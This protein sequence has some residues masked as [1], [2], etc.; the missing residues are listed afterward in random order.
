MLSLG[1]VN[2]LT[3]GGRAA[4]LATMRALVGLCAGEPIEVNVDGG[5]ELVLQAG[6]PPVI[7]GQVDE[8]MRVGCGSAAIGLS[9]SQGAPH[10]AEVVVDDDHI[11]GVLTE[12]QAGVVL[13][14]A[15]SGIRLRGRKSTPGRYFEVAEPGSGWGGT[16]LEDP[17]EIV[18]G[19]KPSVAR[20][21]QTLL[22]IS[23]T[24]NDHAFYV[25]DDDLRL[26]PASLPPELAASV[27]R[28]RENCEPTTTSVLFMAGAGGSLRAGVTDDPVQLTRSVS[29]DAATLTCGGAPTFVWPGGG[30]TFMVDVT[31]T[32][33]GSF[34]YVP[35][36]ALV[37]PLEF[38][39][40]LDTYI[41]L[42]GHAGSIVPVESAL[43]GTPTRLVT[44]HHGNPWPTDPDPR[45]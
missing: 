28:V 34:G 10:V 38:T 11:T 36:P 32:P 24:G 17:L 12:H 5:S 33:P 43:T 21:G 41:R 35:T 44:A 37:A 14:I 27:E 4:G 30:I 42:G 45:W 7:D 15:P 19:F 3:G 1:G 22:M 20:P 25:L 16:D 8:R 13:G 18:A 2:H 26:R 6:A 9:A 29:A 31:R 39:M 40:S 23:T